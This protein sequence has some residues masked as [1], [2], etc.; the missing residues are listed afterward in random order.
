MLLAALVTLADPRARIRSGRPILADDLASAQRRTRAQPAREPPSAERRGRPAEPCGPHKADPALPHDPLMAVMGVF[1]P[2]LAVTRFVRVQ[3]DDRVGPARGGGVEP[4][5]RE[6]DALP[7]CEAVE[8]HGCS[9]R[10]GSEPRRRR[11]W[12]I[13]RPARRVALWSPERAEDD[14]ATPCRAGATA[15][16]GRARRRPRSG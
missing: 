3:A 1:H 7:D 10:G 8:R 12:A 14:P 16:W 5:G 9:F 4:A 11:G 2:V 15:I 6:L 13:G